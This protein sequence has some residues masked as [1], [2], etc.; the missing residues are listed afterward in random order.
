MITGD[1][2]D[3]GR[4]TCQYFDKNYTYTFCGK[5][6]FCRNDFGLAP[7]QTWKLEHCQKGLFLKLTKPKLWLLLLQVIDFHMH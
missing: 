4:L 7:N 5:S 6:P 1:N 3:N 2:D